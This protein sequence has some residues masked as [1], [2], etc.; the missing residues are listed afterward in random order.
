MKLVIFFIDWKLNKIGKMNEYK[1]Y[2][3]YLSTHQVISL[4]FDSIKQYRTSN[5]ISC[6]CSST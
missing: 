6:S 5:L 2:T 1:E 4:I 3:E